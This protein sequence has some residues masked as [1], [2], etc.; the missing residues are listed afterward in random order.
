[1]IL[2]ADLWLIRNKPEEHSIKK[3]WERKKLHVFYSKVW[4]LQSNS[5]NNL[6]RNHFAILLQ[7]LSI[8]WLSSAPVA[9]DWSQLR[10]RW[11]AAIKAASHSCLI[12][13]SLTLVPQGDLSSAAVFC[14]YL[15]QEKCSAS[16]DS[17]VKT[18]QLYNK[19]LDKPPV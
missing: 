9:V 12:L 19:D 13:L 4:I 6:P 5:N 16:Q 14:A 17:A 7:K 8:L 18:R 15:T 1:M 2:Y 11:A 10:M 3:L